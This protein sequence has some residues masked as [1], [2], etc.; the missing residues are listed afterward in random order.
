MMG[1]PRS[2]RGPFLG[3][4]KKNYVSPFSAH[5]LIYRSN[6]GLRCFRGLTSPG[7]LLM[8]HVSGGFDYGTLQSVRHGNH[9]YGDRTSTTSSS[10][11]R[12][13][14]PIVVKCQFDRTF[15]R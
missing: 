15:K 14:R 10:N 1:S 5:H 13:E 12:L 11:D 7:R 8:A 3:R 2:N 6:L 9:D 4:N